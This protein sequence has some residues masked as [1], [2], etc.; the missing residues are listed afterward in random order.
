MIHDPPRLA[1]ATLLYSQGFY[2]E[3]FRVLRPGGKIYHYTGDPGSKKR[4]LDIRAGIIKRMS[5]A[6]FRRV[7]RVFNGLSAEK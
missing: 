6:G 5:Q 7:E 2:D 3:L 1:L 4:G